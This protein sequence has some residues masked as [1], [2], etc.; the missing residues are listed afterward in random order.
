[1]PRSWVALDFDHLPRPHWIDPSDLLGC[2]SV[3]IGTLP[4]AFQGA[5][6]IVQ[7]TASHGLK[8][9]IRIRL[10]TWLSRP[11]VGAELKWWLRKVPIDRSIFGPAQVIYT[12][13][14]IFLSGAHDPLPTRTALISGSPSVRVP[15]RSR[16]KPQQRRPAHNEG[17][18]GS[19][20]GLIRVVETAAVGNRNG[21]LYWATCRAAEEG[22]IDRTAAALDLEAAAVRAG[23]SQQEAAATVRSA[24]RAGGRVR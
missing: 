14:P 1:M 24:L 5:T 4:L 20:A 22:A 19:I 12:S 3:A 9:G 8:P 11:V 2:A 16:L 18:P 13:G 6:F 7:A 10:W 23:L 15:P 21:A 17:S